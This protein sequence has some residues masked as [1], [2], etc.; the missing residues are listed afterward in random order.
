VITLTLNT[1]EK[2]VLLAALVETSYGR[3]MATKGKVYSRYAE[4]S[5]Q[6]GVEPVT[7]RRVLDAIKALAGEGI[8]WAK[9]VSLGRY[10]RTTLVK[11][12]HNPGKLCRELVEDLLVG[13]VAE[14]ICGDQGARSGSVATGDGGW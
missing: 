11:L 10:G 13:E 1:T 7:P 14:R 4:L 12:L 3:G 5:R 6:A 2:L 9:A 8:L